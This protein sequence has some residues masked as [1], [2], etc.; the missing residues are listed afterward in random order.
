MIIVIS[1]MRMKL[2]VK[3]VLIK[4]LGQ[5]RTRLLESFMNQTDEQVNQKPDAEQWSISQVIYHLFSTEKEI[6]ELILNSIKI[7]S[8]KVEERGLSFLTDRSRNVKAAIEPPE[9]YFTKKELLHLLETSR[10]QYL[11]AIFNETHEKTLEGKSVDHPS[12]GLISLKNLVDFIWLH[13]QRHI[14]Q[15][16]EIKMQ[17]E[18]KNMENWELLF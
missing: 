8:K 5:T 15:I 7:D 16:K 11:Q 4:N 17:L 6:A 2:E 10:F 18:N 13:E 12:L 9:D 1:I 3:R 14:E